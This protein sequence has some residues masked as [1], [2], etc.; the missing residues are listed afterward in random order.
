MLLLTKINLDDIGVIHYHLRRS[1]CY[2]LTMMHNNHFLAEIGHCSHYM[3]N[4]QYGGPI[5]IDFTN[6][7]HRLICLRGI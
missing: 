3:L 1:L 5:L 6:Q 7:L 2:F 4:Q